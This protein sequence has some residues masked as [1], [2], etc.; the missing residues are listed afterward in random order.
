M[1]A[2]ALVLFDLDGVLTR[3]D[4]AARLATLAARTG[5]SV[6]QVEVALFDSG[7]EDE[8][9][10]GR[11]RPRE[12]AEELSRRLGANVTLDDCIAARAASMT[13]DATMLA[14]AERA[15]RRVSLGI[16][17]NNGLFLRAH[18]PAMCPALFPL[19]S[20]KVFCSAQY[21]VAKPDP[22]I[23]RRCLA[24]LGAVPERT[25]FIDDKHENVVSAR[26]TGLLAHH[27]RDPATLRTDLHALGLLESNDAP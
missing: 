5:T 18:L 7:L 14:L 24:A 25:L 9:D 23:F 1:A 4:R 21:G 11:W 19:F 22:G 2:P 3:Y 13:A 20:G 15:A 27:Y 16:L 26:A 8:S 6:R 10:L 12:Y 17:T